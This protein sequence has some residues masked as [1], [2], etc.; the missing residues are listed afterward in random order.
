V[1]IYAQNNDADPSNK[2]DI[3]VDGLR[4]TVTIPPRQPG[5]FHA[6]YYHPGVGYHVSDFGPQPDHLIFV[7]AWGT[8][9][10]SSAIMS[11]RQDN[12]VIQ[13]TYD[14][15][16]DSDYNRD[17]SGN[18]NW[19]YRG[20]SGGWPP[21]RCNVIYLRGE[22]G[23]KSTAGAGIAQINFASRCIEYTNSTGSMSFRA[24]VKGYSRAGQRDVGIDMVRVVIDPAIGQLG[25]NINDNSIGMYLNSGFE[26]KI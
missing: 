21:V 3:E 16:F 25:V 8:Q 17:V 13:F 26:V 20:N 19:Y 6:I 5:Q 23:R 10:R 18:G 24:Q 4:D 14:A 2:V 15:D 7:S 12:N 22:C 9:P 1:R 11:Q